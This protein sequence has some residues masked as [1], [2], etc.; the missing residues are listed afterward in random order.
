MVISKENGV[1]QLAVVYWLDHRGVVVMPL[2]ATA[3]LQEKEPSS[4]LTGAR[5]HQATKPEVKT[6]PT[7]VARENSAC[8]GDI[9]N[10]CRENRR[11]A[12]TVL[13]KTLPRLLSARPAASTG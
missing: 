2:P 10:R 9:L 6:A 1:I 8:E 7:K 11:F 3:R 4:P 5:Q 12:A 13:F